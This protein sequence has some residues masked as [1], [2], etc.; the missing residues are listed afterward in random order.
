MNTLVNKLDDR[1]RGG[2]VSRHHSLIWDS[3]R[4]NTNT[5]WELCDEDGSGEL[6][7]LWRGC[8][9]SLFLSSCQEG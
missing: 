8:H 3:L 9:E 5:P 4:R 1:L 2:V 7:E 6:G